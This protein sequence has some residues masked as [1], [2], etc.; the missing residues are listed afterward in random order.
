MAL[1]TSA[2]LDALVSHAQA[3][4]VFEQ[5]NGHEPKNAPTTKGLTAAVWIDR[6]E[7]LAA[8]SGLAAT[9]A[10]LAVNLRIYSSMRM[11]PEDAID[12]NIAAAVSV[13][14]TAYSGDFTLGGLIRNV[15]LL[16]QFGI[17]LH[18][19]AGYLEQDRVMYRVMTITL[20][21]IVNDAWDQAA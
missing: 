2:I 1:D 15:D 16:G 10:R 17:G 18:A 14:F 19:Q 6:I 21:L 12:P 9:T 3:S 13:L 11:E 20:P 4:G 5:V 7:P 8:A